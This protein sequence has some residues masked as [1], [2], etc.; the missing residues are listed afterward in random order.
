MYRLIWFQH[1]HKA[2]GSSIINQAVANG[3]VLFPG[4]QN[5]NPFNEEGEVIPL[6]D[7]DEVGLRDFVD[8]C[9]TKK[10]TFVATEW[11]APN[12]GTLH[13]D[14]RVVLLTCIREPWSRLISNF[15][16]AHYLGFS[17]SA[18][19]AE[20]LVEDRRI[21]MDNLL[22]RIFAN[23]FLAERGSIGKD[24]LSN[25]LSNLSL[26]D[27]VIVTEREGDLS[28]HLFEALGWEKMK[29]DSHSTFGNLWTLSMLVRRL[30]LASAI[31]YILKMKMAVSDD[32]R[33][34]FEEQSRIDLEFYDRI[35]E[36]E[37]R[38]R[39]HPLNLESGE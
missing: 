10:V 36:G 33:H 2:A 26:F 13:D 5:G 25:A 17:N 1:V 23:E 27:L 21:M 3:E 9:Q 37:I 20:Y 35:M 8:E 15:N 6:W 11:G 30:R 34:L 7:F 12:F 16:Y 18:T 22:V 24:S 38:G 19:L 14:P 28:D 29:V 32:E 31:R 39:L 4:H